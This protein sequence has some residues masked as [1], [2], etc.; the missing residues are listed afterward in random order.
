M[1]Y[2]IIKF[3]KIKDSL[4]LSEYGSHNLRERIHANR[5]ESIETDRSALN[6][7]IVNK[8]DAKGSDFSKKLS[9]Y[10]EKR[11]VKVKKNSVMGV[12]LI[13][14]T[15]PEWW[16]DWRN[17]PKLEEKLLKWQNSQYEY[18]KKTFGEDA[19]LSCV[20]HLDETT[21]HLH[22]FI[23][24]EHE[25]SRK[26][27]N[28]YKEYIKVEKVLDANRWPPAFWTKV[29]DDY[30][31]HNKN[32]GLRRGEVGSD[33]KE[34]PLKEY[35]KQLQKA[36]QRTE[37][38]AEAYA[39]GIEDDEAKKALIIKAGKEVKFWKNRAIVAEEQLARM[40]TLENVKNGITPTDEELEQLGL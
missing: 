25:K 24:P 13:C 19:I 40:K 4:K 31:E 2:C 27:K 22:F 35:K 32:L 39:R 20:L 18:V 26:I 12:D 29:V 23:S 28:R 14:T 6:R 16:G 1:D 8:L 3:K 5:K 36:I 9:E 11:D 17:D 21:P 34:T 33:A 38:L 7:V 37:K 15:S 30:A 10:Y